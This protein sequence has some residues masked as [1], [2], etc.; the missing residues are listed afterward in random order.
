MA[1]PSIGTVAPSFTLLDQDGVEHTL[2]E[3]KG[4][5]ALVYFYPKDDTSG[6]TKEACSLGEYMPDFSKSDAVIFGI[7]ADSVKS[8]KKFAEKYGLK[9][10]L[11]AD[12]D[13]QAINAYGV[14]GQK[15]FMG[16]NYEGISRTS[17]LIPPDGTIAKVYESVK[18][19]KH[20]EEVLADL[21]TL[22]G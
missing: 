22:R 7:S 21:A 8:H 5:Y 16:R 12:P 4:K 20:A 1:F 17:F 15:K 2:S 3:V 9:F 19:E 6:C 13:H 10:T 11:L 14:W 18:P